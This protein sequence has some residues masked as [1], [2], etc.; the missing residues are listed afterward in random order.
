MPHTFNEELFEDKIINR[1]TTIMKSIMS[2]PKQ[3]VHPEDKTVLHEHPRQEQQHQSHLSAEYHQP[4][5]FP[6]THYNFPVTTLY[7]MPSSYSSQAPSPPFLSSPTLY[8]SNFQQS[9]NQ[10]SVQFRHSVP[11][12]ADSTQYQTQPPY[13]IP[14][15]LQSH[16]TSFYQAQQY[17]PPYQIQTILNQAYPPT[18]PF[19]APS[20]TGYQFLSAPYHQAPI[21]LPPYPQQ[22]HHQPTFLQASIPP[23]GHYQSQPSPYYTQ[24]NQQ[25]FMPPPPPHQ[26]K[27]HHDYRDNGG[28]HLY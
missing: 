22:T 6:Q 15:N 4:P 24:V 5:S 20:P 8:H 13:Q 3:E 26:Q 19:L 21:S 7:S 12:Q 1:L 14:S 23:P 28:N 18:P 11:H 2:V 10:A 16:Q 17:P 25:Q 27:N 9:Q